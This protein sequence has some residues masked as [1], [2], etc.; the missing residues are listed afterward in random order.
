MKY[1]IIYSDELYHHGVK[2]MKWGVRKEWNSNYSDSQRIRDKAVYGRGGV[3]RINK[4]LNKGHSISG[5]RSIEADRINAARRRAR[6]AGQVGGTAGKVGGAVA[7]LILSK[8]AKQKIG[9]ESMQMA[10]TPVVSFGASTVAGQLGRYG[11]QSIAM[12]MSGYSPDKF[13]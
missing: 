2:G 7:G 10:I 4:S 3:K 1:K 12:I 9:D 11:G 8:Y 5:A 13:R 6:V